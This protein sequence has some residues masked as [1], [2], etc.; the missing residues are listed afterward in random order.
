VIGRVERRVLGI[1]GNRSPTSQT[2]RP[3]LSGWLVSAAP[4]GFHR[5]PKAFAAGRRQRYYRRFYRPRGLLSEQMRAIRIVSRGAVAEPQRHGHI[6][7]TGLGSFIASNRGI[8]SPSRRPAR[9]PSSKR[10]N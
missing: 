3:R 6:E 9:A 10:R 2:W 4:C 7:V 1:Y 5:V 8:V